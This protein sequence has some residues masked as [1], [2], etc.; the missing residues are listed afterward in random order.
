VF[1]PLDESRGWQPDAD[2]LAHLL[3]PRT[4]AILLVTPNNPTGALLSRAC[5]EA[6]GALAEARDLRHR[7]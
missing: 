7:R 4:K 1:W 3:T 2:R 6:V 5:L